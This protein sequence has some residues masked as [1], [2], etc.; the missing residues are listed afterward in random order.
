MLRIKR[1]GVKIKRKDIHYRYF[2]DHRP[3]GW[4]ENLIS[5]DNFKVKRILVNPGQSLSLQSHK[6]RSEH[7]VV[8]DGEAKVTIEKIETLLVGQ[9]AY[10]PAK[11]S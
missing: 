1:C 2:K 6:Y 10:I 11:N 8:V 5:K 7:W 3:W 9:S 4:L